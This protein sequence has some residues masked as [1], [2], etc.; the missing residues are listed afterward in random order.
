[1]LLLPIVSKGKYN[2]SLARCC[3]LH[4]LYYLDIMAHVHMLVSHDGWK[5]EPVSGSALSMAKPLVT[6]PY[7]FGKIIGKKMK[8]VLG[9]EV[10][11]L[12]KKNPAKT[13]LSAGI[14]FKYGGMDYLNI[15][16]NETIKDFLK[17]L[18]GVFSNQMFCN[19]DVMEKCKPGYFYT[20]KSPFCQNRYPVCSTSL[21]RE[22]GT[23]ILFFEQYYVPAFIVSFFAGFQKSLLESNLSES[24]PNQVELI[25]TNEEI[26]SSPR[27]A[28]EDEI[29]RIVSYDVEENELRRLCKDLGVDCS[30]NSGLQS[31]RNELI[32]KLNINFE[33]GDNKEHAIYY[34]TSKRKLREIAQIYRSNI[35]QYEYNDKELRQ[36]ILRNF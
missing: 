9:E 22:I 3:N 8:E 1:M 27:P 31:I 10:I 14:F 34:K 13:G 33:P 21:G 5:I 36:L 15:I 29:L 2:P 12:I 6:A 32:F 4:A 7:E 35:G 11:E 18:W 19:D 26:Q 20:D 25:Q 24:E 28:T 17:F 16:D 23:M 30:N